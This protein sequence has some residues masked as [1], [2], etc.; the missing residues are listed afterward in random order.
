MKPSVDCPFN[1]PEIYPIEK[2]RRKPQPLSLYVK[3]A[4]NAYFKDLNGHHPV[5]LYELVLSEVERPLLEVVMNHSKGNLSKA[6]QVLGLNRATLR[7][8]LKKYG[9]NGSSQAEGVQ[10]RTLSEE[11]GRRNRIE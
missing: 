5:K 8:K 1:D 7:K 10:G 11:R 2:E 4:V 3:Q 9:L 6:A